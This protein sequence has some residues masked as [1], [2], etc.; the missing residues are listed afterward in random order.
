MS[1]LSQLSSQTGDRSEYSNRKVVLQCL[2]DPDLLSEIAEGLQSKNAALLGDCAEVFT[3][4]AEQQSEWVLPYAQALPGLLRHKNTRVRWEAMHALALLAPSA[5][6]LIDPLL[7]ELGESIQD[8]RSVI[9]RD[10]AVDALANYAASSTSAAE[11][12]Y[13]LLKKALTTWEGKQA[14]HALKGLVNVV[15]V[16]PLLADDAL[17]IAEEYAQSDRS[18]VRKAAKSLLKAIKGAQTKRAE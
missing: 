14:A 15:T 6:A 2:D 16:L 9:V 7:T 12:A 8:D 4:V 18:V 1:I 17:P 11:K 5:P 13:P 3:M 10:Y